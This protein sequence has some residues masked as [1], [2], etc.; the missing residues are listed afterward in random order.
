MNI[1]TTDLYAYAA[2]AVLTVLL[3]VSIYTRKVIIPGIR[4]KKARKKADEIMRRKALRRLAEINDAN[5]IWSRT[6]S[7]DTISRELTKSQ[8]RT[9]GQNY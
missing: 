4:M 7:H 6:C 8:R 9:I 1:L 2:L 5:D 3:A